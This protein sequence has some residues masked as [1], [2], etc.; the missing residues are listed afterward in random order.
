MTTINDFIMQK[1]EDRCAPD[2]FWLSR[3]CHQFCY[4]HPVW[5]L[6]SCHGFSFSFEAQQTFGKSESSVWGV[7]CRYISN[8]NTLNMN[9]TKN[10]VHD[11]KCLIHIW[12]KE[13]VANISIKTLLLDAVCGSADDRLSQKEMLFYVLL[14]VYFSLRA[15]YTFQHANCSFHRH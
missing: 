15:L 12:T 10:P 1:L 6:M 3:C 11:A 14:G 9:K 2:V 5:G 13:L 4:W 8:H 7:F